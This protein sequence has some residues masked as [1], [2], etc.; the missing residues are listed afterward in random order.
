MPFLAWSRGGSEIGMWHAAAET[1]TALAS[2]LQQVCGA[3]VIDN[4][5]NFDSDVC[6]FAYDFGDV[7]EANDVSY[8]IFAFSAAL[9]VIHQHSLHNGADIAMGLCVPIVFLSKRTHLFVTKF[10]FHGAFRCQPCHTFHLPPHQKKR[11]T[12]K[13]NSVENISKKR[14]ICVFRCWLNCQYRH[15]L[16]LCCH[17]KKTINHPTP[18]WSAVPYLR[19]IAQKRYPSKLRNFRCFLVSHRKNISGKRIF[20]V[21]ER[22]I[23][24]DQKKRPRRTSLGQKRR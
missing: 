21:T 15:P 16:K 18:S 3:P 19:L 22:C 24:W 6:D 8:L 20:V 14:T 1:T 17:L 2:N 13:Y 10:F 5:D 11:D 12:R 23:F 7:L 9:W 4:S